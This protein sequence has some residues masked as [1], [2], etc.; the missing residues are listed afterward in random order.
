MA[1]YFTLGEAQGLL[2]TVE[3]IMRRIQSFHE[4]Y[5]AAEAGIQELARRVMISG[6]MQLNFGVLAERKR[7][8]DE[9]EMRF[10]E[11]IGDLHSLGCL[12]K[13]V[14]A[15][16]VDFP[17]QLRGEEVCL[18]WKLGEKGISFWHGADEGFSGRKKI[19]REFLDHH[20][21]E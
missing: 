16:L 13:D 3:P 15:G 7:R 5:R 2:G 21:C 12:L 18:C 8:L 14:D 6:G 9:S 1:R 11:S 4:A 10:R 20:G 17:T 19:D